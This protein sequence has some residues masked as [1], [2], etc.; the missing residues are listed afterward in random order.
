MSAGVVKPDYSK[1][2][3]LVVTDGE[4]RFVFLIEEVQEPAPALPD[5]TQVPPG[6]S[7]VDERGNLIA[8]TDEILEQIRKCEIEYTGLAVNTT[9]HTMYKSVGPI[10]GILGIIPECKGQYQHTSNVQKGE[11]NC[12]KRCCYSYA[13]YGLDIDNITNLQHLDENNIKT[14][15]AMTPRQITNWILE[16][17]NDV[18]PSTSQYYLCAARQ[19]RHFSQGLIKEGQWDLPGGWM[20]NTTN[21]FLT[22]VYSV[23]LKIN[24]SLISPSGV[25]YAST[26]LERMANPGDGLPSKYSVYCLLCYFANN[27]WAFARQYKDSVY[28]VLPWY[29][30]KN[31]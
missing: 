26:G 6:V 12:L 18:D 4:H 27:Q 15:C 16:S 10:I 25:I 17:E 14:A 2:A 30:L 31:P 8:A 28:R 7:I 11:W 3:P 23:A 24:P 9:G 1:T 29:S 13:H 20:F 22:Q 5:W 21:E 19:V